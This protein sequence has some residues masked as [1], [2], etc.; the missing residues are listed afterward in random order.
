MSNEAA[1][2]KPSLKLLVVSTYPPKAC[3]IGTF[4]HSLLDGIIEG[5]GRTDFRVLAIEDPDEHNSYEWVVRQRIEKED[6]ASLDRAA[7]YT[8][9][10]GA[11]ALSIQH[12]FGIWGGFDGEFILHFLD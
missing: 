9:A 3:G 2:L 10:C 6:L 8:N 4:T 1:A 12:E 11:D 7:A 5:D